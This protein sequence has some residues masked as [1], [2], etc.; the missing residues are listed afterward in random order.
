MSR[1]GYTDD[2]DDT[3][4]MGRWRAQVLSATRGRRGQAFFKELAA[5]M[6]VM[7]EKRLIAGELVDEDRECCAIGVVCKARG[8][9]DKALLIDEYDNE[10]VGNFVGIACQLVGE[11]SYQNDEVGWNE[12]PEQRWTRMRA[13]VG[14]QIKVQETPSE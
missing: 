13:W 9:E 8:L 7:P 5:A 12:T 3:L 6:D 14:K 2:C 11:I 4:A 1:S 10:A